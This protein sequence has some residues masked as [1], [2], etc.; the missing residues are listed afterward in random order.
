MFFL[1]I[2]YQQYSVNTLPHLNIL[3]EFVREKKQFYH[4]Y[5][6]PMLVY[7]CIF[8]YLSFFTGTPV[9]YVQIPIQTAAP[10]RK[11]MHALGA[12]HAP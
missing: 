5:C 4:L 12:T 1:V 11:D 10:H 7:I 9:N 2:P 6:M 3:S 8:T